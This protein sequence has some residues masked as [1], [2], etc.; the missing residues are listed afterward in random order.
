[1]TKEEKRGAYLSGFV[2]V[3]EMDCCLQSLAGS[4][5]REE[6]NLQ[7]LPWLEKTRVEKTWT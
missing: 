3:A 5:L 4:I 2:A 6:S 7:I 1:M